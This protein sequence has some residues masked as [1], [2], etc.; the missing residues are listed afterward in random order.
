MSGFTG[1]RHARPANWLVAA[2]VAGIVALAGAAQAQE[3]FTRAGPAQGEFAAFADDMG[4]ITAGSTV[5]LKGRGL[6]PGAQITLRQGGVALNGGQPVTVAQDGTFALQV[7]IPKT[8]P[9]GPY[10]VVAEM[11]DPAYA[12][13]FDVRVTA[14]LGPIGTDQFKLS[15]TDGVPGL[16]QVVEA[17][18]LGAIY[19]A[20]AN[21]RPPVEKSSVAKY[22]AK[23]M[24]LLAEVT[25][26]ASDK[27]GVY[28]V[29]GLDVDARAGQVWTTN[30]RQNTVAVYST[31]DL[32]LIKQ[33][34]DGAVAHPR[35]VRI[36]DGKAYVSATFTPDIEVFDIATLEH[37]GTIELHSGKRG[38]VFGNGGMMIDAKSGT[39]VVASL[40]SNEVA[41]VD[42]ATGK[43]VGA[44]PVPGAERVIGVG[45]DAARGHI[46]TANSGSGDVSILDAGS[47]K[48]IRTVPVGSGP[49][50]VAVAGNGDVYV[51]VRSS[52][53][54]VVLSPEG[55]VIGNLAIGSFP[56]QL[57]ADAEGGVLVVNKRKGGD[58]P[59]GDKITRIT[60]AS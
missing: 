51:A 31:D 12:T 16:Y 15:Q 4:P 57:A 6:T 54:V 36:Y 49:L 7:Q 18:S 52:G 60:P 59:T 1:Q 30:T 41:V 38:E 55:D 5:D 10:P 42:L 27:G 22:D 45:Y 19:V 37:V 26:A 25:P 33:F 2:A 20:A 50:N 56:N 14:D 43:Q 11:A 13:T 8:A 58:D 9:V 44:Y 39:M 35:D 48:L 29:Y 53:T 28:A 34:P 24:K 46:Y 3:A 47:G 21:G 32:K 17:P 40:G 23:T